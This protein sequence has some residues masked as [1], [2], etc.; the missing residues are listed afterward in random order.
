[1][2]HITP[3]FE[4]DL[5][6]YNSDAYL[7][8]ISIDGTTVSDFDPEIFTYS[9]N[10]TEGTTKIPEIIFTT[11]SGK[12]TVELINAVDLTGDEPSRTSTIVVTAED[13]I[14]QEIY[15]IL[16]NVY[17]NI[18]INAISGTE[19]TIFPVPVQETLT[20][21]G[22]SSVGKLEIIDYAGKKLLIREISGEQTEVNLSELKVGIYFLKIE[23]KIMK[24]LKH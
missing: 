11:T 23:N 14:T 21:K 17:T 10:L 15:E 19:I 7:S 12:T 6:I 3:R 1:M 24:I 2:V 8:S 4:S 22:L 16:F 13:G 20:I 18:R 5:Y 9:V